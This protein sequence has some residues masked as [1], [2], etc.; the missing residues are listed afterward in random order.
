MDRVKSLTYSNA[1]TTPK[2]TMSYDA[3]GNRSQM[4]DGAGTVN[5]VYDDLNQMASATRGFDV[6]FYSYYP[7]SQLKQVTYP[8]NPIVGYQYE[9]RRPHVHGDPGGGHHRLHVPHRGNHHLRLRQGRRPDHQDVPGLQ[10]LHRDTGLR[11][12][13]P[14]P[15][16]W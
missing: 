9:P 1:P 12:R 11:Q 15:P 4:T 16:A 7:G 5:Y 13:R 2:V 14:A 10:R 6:F 8:D 3:N